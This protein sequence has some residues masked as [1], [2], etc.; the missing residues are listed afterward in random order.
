MIK[1][2]NSS[3][4]YRRC[5]VLSWLRRS[6]HPCFFSNWLPVLAFCVHP[7]VLWWNFRWLVLG[8]WPEKRSHHHAMT[9]G[10]SL[11]TH[12]FSAKNM[13]FF[14]NKWCLLR[15]RF[16][17]IQHHEKP[18]EIFQGSN[19]Y[20]FF[21]LMFSQ[22]LNVVRIITKKPSTSLPCCISSF[23]DGHGHLLGVHGF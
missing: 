17:G 13:C 3:V 7:Q 22:H 15:I 11:T 18:M 23:Q 19:L 4:P 6:I 2:P 12:F 5:G 14:Y 1:I 10:W 9:T 21:L 20:M 16:Y 8:W